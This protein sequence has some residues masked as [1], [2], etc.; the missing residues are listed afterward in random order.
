MK[1][2]QC[3]VLHNLVPFVQ[4]KKGKKHLWRLLACNFTKSKT[5]PWVLF[6]FIKLHKLYQI[7][8]RITYEE[9]YP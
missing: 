4:F 1:D 6:T 9:K 2:K 8:Q 3:D 7:V 5:P